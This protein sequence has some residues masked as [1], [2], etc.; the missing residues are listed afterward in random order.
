[1]Y[2]PVNPVVY[3][4]VTKDGR[5]ELIRGPAHSMPSVCQVGPVTL[6]RGPRSEVSTCTVAL[7]PGQVACN[8]AARV[9]LA[10]LTVGIGCT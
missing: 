2:Q 1:M 5:G 6:G 10:V 3:S 8:R 4:R 9:R 7:A